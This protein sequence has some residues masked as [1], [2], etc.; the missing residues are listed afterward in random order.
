M[1]HSLLVQPRWKR[2]TRAKMR[3]QTQGCDVWNAG[4]GLLVVWVDRVIDNSGGAPDASD[5][6]A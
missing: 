6:S 5:A 4:G 3:F 2:S 1:D